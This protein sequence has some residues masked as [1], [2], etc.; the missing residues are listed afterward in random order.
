MLFYP[1]FGFLFSTFYG[2][3]RRRTKSYRKIR[4]IGIRARSARSDRRP[5]AIH[6]IAKAIQEQ[7]KENEI[8]VN[9]QNYKNP[10]ADLI[11]KKETV[12]I[13][14]EITGTRNSNLLD[15]IT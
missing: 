10:K 11:L 14:P 8:T 4:R 5:E 7:L 3:V 1:E 2:H 9:I 13:T 6:Q 15:N 12:P